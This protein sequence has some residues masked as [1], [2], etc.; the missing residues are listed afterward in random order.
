MD[1]KPKVEELNI[2]AAHNGVM[3]TGRNDC[4]R[5]GM[6]PTPHVFNSKHDLF[7]YLEECGVL[8]NTTK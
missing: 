5:G 7:K 6:A 1:N 3:V 8:D 4:H 2:I